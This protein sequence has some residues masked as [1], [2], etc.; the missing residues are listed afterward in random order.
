MVATKLLILIFEIFRE[1]SVVPQSLLP[2]FVAPADVLAEIGQLV[3]GVDQRVKFVCVEGQVDKP[4]FSGQQSVQLF[5]KIFSFLDGLILLFLEYF[6]VFRQILAELVV[7]PELPFDFFEV[8]SL[9][10]FMAELAEITGSFI[11][12]EDV[13][14]VQVDSFFDCPLHEFVH[15]PDGLH[16][17]I[18]HFRV[19]SEA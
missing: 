4:V 3:Q 6:G 12:F 2:S 13:G 5:D 17:P 16:E 19:I 15:H 9:L 18:E 14:C 10:D 1:A 8:I 11:A 7:Q